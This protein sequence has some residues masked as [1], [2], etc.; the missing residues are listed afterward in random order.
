MTKSLFITFEGGE[1]SGKTTQSKRL[2]EYFKSQNIPCIWTREPGG[3]KVAEV[4]REVLIHNDM[5]VTTELLLA[6]AARNEHLHEV[7]FPA[8]KAGQVVICDRFIDSS[9]CYQG[10]KLG[11]DKVLHLHKEVFGDIMPDM[12][13]FIDVPV[14]E[15]LARAQNRGGN[16]R[17][18]S[19]PMETHEKLRQC[20]NK[21]VEIFPERI[22]KIDGLKT[23][24]EIENIII[25]RIKHV[26]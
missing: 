13:F 12:T 3:T 1:G 26:K 14:K 25:E 7:I 22:I 19:V 4:I 17:F 15:G 24:N 21:L 20:F 5:D 18:E 6:L 8:L 2:L 16:N 9:L 11:V 23:E 10:H